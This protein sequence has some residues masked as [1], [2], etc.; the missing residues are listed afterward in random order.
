MYIV[1]MQHHKA[2]NSNRIIWMIS[3]TLW[4]HLY[5]FIFIT[6]GMVFIRLYRCTSS[7]LV[8]MRCCPFPIPARGKTQTVARSQNQ[9]LSSCE[10][11]SAGALIVQTSNYS[12][13]IFSLFCAFRISQHFHPWITRAD[14]E[15][16]SLHS[17]DCDSAK[18]HNRKW[19]VTSDLTGNSHIRK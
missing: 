18:I 1:N 15:G 17:L 11:P 4:I 9:S 10:K 6:C 3:S 8:G 7:S 2:V 16:P 19:D 5:L 14:D 13:N 12:S